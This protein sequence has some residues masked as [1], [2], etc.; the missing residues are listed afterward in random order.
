MGPYGGP[1]RNIQ[2]LGF[3]A[4]RLTIWLRFIAELVVPN[5]NYHPTHD[6]RA[7][8]VIATES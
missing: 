5:F 6:I 4:G 3:A 2:K 7:T 8:Y 1:V